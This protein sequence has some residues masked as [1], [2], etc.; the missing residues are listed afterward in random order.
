[1]K[2]KLIKLKKSLWFKDKWV[3]CDEIFEINDNYIPNKGDFFIL[4]KTNT[5]Y[6]CEGRVIYGNVGMKL[7][8][9]EIKNIDKSY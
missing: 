8:V 1:M 2:V 3:E 6:R 9:E 4:E 7:Y 5:I